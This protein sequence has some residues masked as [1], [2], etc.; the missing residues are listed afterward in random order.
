MTGCHGIGLFPIIRCGFRALDMKGNRHDLFQFTFRPDNLANLF[1]VGASCSGIE[2]MSR[3][4]IKRSSAYSETTCM[5]SP[6]G[7]PHISPCWRNICASGSMASEN[8]SGESGH[9]WRVPLCTSIGSE[10][11]WPVL[12]WL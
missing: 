9:P 7:M 2:V 11:S 12:T 8:Y 1:K 4:Y 3:M 6:I 5:P 10:R